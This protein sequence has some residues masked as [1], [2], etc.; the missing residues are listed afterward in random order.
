MNGIL[1]A[2]TPNEANDTAS[3]RPSPFSSAFAAAISLCITLLVIGG[4]A[5]WSFAQSPA[6]NNQNPA[7]SFDSSMPVPTV[8]GNAGNL[9]VHA[10]KKAI[11]ID[12]EHTMKRVSIDDPDL[13]PLWDSMSGRLWKRID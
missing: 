5:M 13:K 4:G 6:E 7:T 3:I 1:I 10:L 12:D 9:D 11:A 2:H 8:F